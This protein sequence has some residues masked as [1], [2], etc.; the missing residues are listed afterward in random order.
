LSESERKVVCTNRR[1]HRQ[2][3]L[4]ETFEAGLVLT[5]SEVKALRAGTAHLRDSYGRIRGGEAFLVKAYI[6]A[7]E[8]ANRANHDPD[9]ERKL[10]LH[11]REID[12]L[13]VK[14]RERGF[15]LVPLEVYFERGFAKV[16]LALA[17]GKKTH[18]RRRDIARKEAEERMRRARGRRAKR[19]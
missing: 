18:D 8:Q 6:A 17:R 11:R 5:G 4:E 9:R 15:T 7:Y 13:R 3:Q 10:L 16:R 2:Y 19:G 1:A 14:V 12:R